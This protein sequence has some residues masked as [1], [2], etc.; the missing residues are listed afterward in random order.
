AEHGIGDASVPGVQTCALPISYF[1][2]PDAISWCS[3]PILQLHIDMHLYSVIYSASVILKAL[4]LSPAWGWIVYK[5]NVYVGK[6]QLGQALRDKIKLKVINMDRGQ[7]SMFF[8]NIA[9][10]LAHLDVLS[11]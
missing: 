6:R 2:S 10:F 9:V 4:R 5:I 1:L 11:V 7:L 3:S 8:L